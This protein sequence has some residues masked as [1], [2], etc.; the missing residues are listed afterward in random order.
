M[1]LR[2]P[3]E[4]S[5]YLSACAAIDVNHPSIRQQAECLAQTTDWQTA[6][7][8]FEWVRDH[9]R[10]SKDYELVNLYCT[11][12]DVLRHQTG[13]CFAKA[14]LLVALLR[15][16]G[17]PA[18]L[19]Y[20]RLS[21][22]GDGAPYS[23]HGL[24]AVYL[25]EHGWY[26]I[27]PRGNKPGVNAQFCPPVEQLAFATQDPQ[28]RDFQVILAKPLPAVVAALTSGVSV[29]TLYDQLPDASELS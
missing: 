12:S 27:D 1:T 15:A 22:K 3:D 20:Q 8:C 23:L 29:Q 11:A 16:N 5:D 25:S 26:R 9:I 4:H 21:L 7:A 28:E 17:I 19:C 6:Q 24:A 18:G 2:A 10:H 13:Y 14:H